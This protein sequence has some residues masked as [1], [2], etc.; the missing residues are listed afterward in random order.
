MWMHH[1]LKA[2][3]YYYANIL[4]GHRHL[5]NRQIHLLSDEVLYP[6]IIDRHRH[7]MMYILKIEHSVLGCLLKQC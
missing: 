3:G 1:I 7:V 2:N 5:L 6:C 4:H